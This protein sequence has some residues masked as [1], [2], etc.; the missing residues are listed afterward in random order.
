MPDD[1]PLLAVSLSDDQGLDM[2]TISL[3]LEGLYHD[4][5]RVGDLLLVVEEYLLTNDLRHE[6]A[7][8]A[9][10]QRILLKVG[11]R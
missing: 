10:G 4:L 2:D 11:G 6:E 3:L 9:I 7:G 1:D 8:R 5:H